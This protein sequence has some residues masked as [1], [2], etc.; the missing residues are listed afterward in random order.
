MTSPAR[1]DLIAGVSVLE[2]RDLFDQSPD[3]FYPERIIRAGYSA[4]KLA[5]VLDALAENSYILAAEDG[6]VVI[7]AAG[8]AFAAGLRQCESPVETLSRPPRRRV[9]PAR[10]PPPPDPDESRL[11]EE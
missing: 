11:P 9:M 2:V 1:S 7:T 10:C 3:G 5:N 4:Q 6:L 8:R